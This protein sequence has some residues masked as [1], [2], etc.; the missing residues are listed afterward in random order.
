MKQVFNIYA[1]LSSGTLKLNIDS[2]N[3]SSVSF[4]NHVE[5]NPKFAL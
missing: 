5:K 3:L 1:R 2:C 4:Y